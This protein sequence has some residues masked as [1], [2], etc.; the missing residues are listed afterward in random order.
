LSTAYIALGANL[1]NPIA[2]LTSALAGLGSLPATRLLKRSRWYRSRAIGPGVQTD[3]INGVVL[4]ETSLSPIALLHELLRL[5]ES[6]GR[7]R[8]ERWAPRT[9]D[10]DILLYDDLAF[11]SPELHIPHPRMASR[12]FVLVPLMDIAPELT[13]PNGMPLAKLAQ[14]IGEEGLWLMPETGEAHGK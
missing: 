7:T 9:L 13:L 6:H 5:E 3:Y 12:N 2:Q 10:L 14:S 1:G 11:E 4:L 8:G